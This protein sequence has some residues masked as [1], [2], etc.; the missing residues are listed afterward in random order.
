MRLSILC[1]ALAAVARAQNNA[2]H[3]TFPDGQIDMTPY[4]RQTVEGFWEGG[5][6][7]YDDPAEPFFTNI[8][9]SEGNAKAW[10]YGKTGAMQPLVWEAPPGIV[11]TVTSQVAMAGQ[12]VN[13]ANYKN[14][15]D[16]NTITNVKLERPII[17]AELS[18]TQHQSYHDTWDHM[19]TIN[20]NG[21]QHG[22]TKEIEAK[23]RL[24]MKAKRASNWKKAAAVRHHNNGGHDKLGKVGYGKEA[25]AAKSKYSKER[26]VKRYLKFG[27]WNDE[28]NK[29]AAQATRKNGHGEAKGRLNK[30]KKKPTF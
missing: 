25:T 17:D 19:S 12:S 14:E 2:P 3:G 16:S 15:N 30:G 11:D 29:Y 6:P 22:T 18:H 24:V 20:A 23:K 8:F 5:V 7:R 21:R 4:V 28:Q 27:T 1:V 26:Q 9:A 13:N 10:V